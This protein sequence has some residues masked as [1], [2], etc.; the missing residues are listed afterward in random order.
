M[1]HEI[2]HT[3]A[4]LLRAPA[5]GE[6]DRLL[7]LYTRQLGRVVAVAQGVRKES[8]KLRFALVPRGFARVAL[9]A[10]RE[11]WR[12]TGAES[13]GYP[14]LPTRATRAH[15][16]RLTD[17]LD[18]LVHGEEQH[19]E[20]FLLLA[21]AH[22]ALADPACSAEAAECVE[23]LALARLLTLLGYVGEGQLPRELLTQGALTDP[24]ARAAAL[25]QRAVLVHVINDALA[26]SHL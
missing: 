24:A 13:A 15:F 18:R 7:V 1:S 10:G 17:M 8:S 5:R 2:H 11:V 20:L 14:P 3:D 16:R 12:L 21:E 19:E 6:A 22:T 9:V 25:A 4:C 23:H 26:A